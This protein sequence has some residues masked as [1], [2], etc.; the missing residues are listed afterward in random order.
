[1]RPT[2]AEINLKLLNNNID[3]IKSYLDPNTALMTVV[4][5]NAYGHG[6]IDIGKKA[7]KSGARSLGVA[8]PE[9]GAQ[10][11]EAGIACDIL[12]LGSISPNQ[13]ELVLDYNLSVCIFS[14]DIA[15]LLNQR[16]KEKN[17]NIKVHIKIDSGMGR[18]GVRD[19]DEAL[20]LC[21]AIKDMKNLILEGVFTHFACADECGSKYS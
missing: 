20:S 18:I 10:L 17:K 2:R 7:L 15:E 5:A 4:K 14:H 11:R 21:F 8:I 12:V 13:I 1:M 9:E 19:S 3:K 16:A 6:I